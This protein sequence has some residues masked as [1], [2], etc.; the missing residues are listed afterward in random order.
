M[1]KAHYDVFRAWW[2]PVRNAAAAGTAPPSFVRDALLH[3]DTRYTGDDETAM[4]LAL[5]VI[6]A[7]SDNMWLT[8]N[9]LVMAALCHPAVFARARG[10]ID[11]VCGD[12][13]GGGSGGDGGA[14]S[15]TVDNP[16]LHLPGIADM[17]PLPFVSAIVKELLRWRPLVPTIPPHNLMQD[18]AFENYFFP[19]GTSFVVN[20]VAVCGAVEDPEAFR[21]ER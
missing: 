7:E 14:D 11:V 13:G 6:L 2:G 19:A 1:G 12:G 18:L 4:Y 3:P 21:P 9:T 20:S 15:G 16:R 10:E 17:P 8:L 5:S